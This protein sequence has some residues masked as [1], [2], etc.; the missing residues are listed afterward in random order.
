MSTYLKSLLASQELSTPQQQSLDAHKA[1]VELFLR[2]E[3]GQSP[4]I[5]IAGSVS[6]GTAVSDSY[7]LDVVMYFPSSDTR[8]LKAIYQEVHNKLASR[9][10]IDPKTSALR[11]TGVSNASN[12]SDYHIDV[13][14]GRFIPGTK[15]VFLYMNS[16]DRE[17]MQ[18]NLKTHIDYITQSGC[19][20]IIKLVKL[21]K[22]R[23]GVVFKTFILEL[24]VIDALQGTHDKSD[25]ENG[26]KKVME[27]FVN[28]VH[29]ELVDP[30][31]TANVVSRTISDLGRQN[32]KA[33]AQET[34]DIMRKHAADDKWKLIF[35]EEVITELYP[36]AQNRSSGF[37]PTSP[38]SM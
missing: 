38:W 6:K 14:P 3:F 5:K 33:R 19:Q 28:N 18:T 1:E 30:A 17:R 21:W 26:F 37:T 11:I 8:T 35:K 27:A 4:I 22:V 24:F 20:E 31:N 10:T 16:A 34:F 25:L 32:M 13:V 23:N 9:Y 12:N 7:D 36:V 29:V 2:Q 15:D